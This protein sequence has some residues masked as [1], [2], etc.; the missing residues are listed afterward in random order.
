ML[1]A[2]ASLLVLS[3]APQPQDGAASEPRTFQPLDVFELEWAADPQVSPDGSRVVYVRSRFAVMTDA[4]RTDLWLLALDETPI[5]HRPLVT[6][7]ANVSSPRWSPSGDRLLYVSSEDA[8]AQI[9]C[10][11]MES[12][13]TAALTHVTE[14][15]GSLAWSPDGS[16][17]AFT[18]F[19]PK[20]VKPFA[21]MPPKPEGATWAEAPRVV[22][23]LRA[24]AEA[25]GV[26]RFHLGLEVFAEAGRVH[27][28]AS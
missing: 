19:V 5:G 12:G 22:E 21:E 28:L 26:V 4:T 3:A 6:G 24:T 11:W 10:R 27:N 20:K 18:M 25:F 8:G 17:I 9:F 23:R 2:A 14:S 15:P 16:K 1:F 7:P 13:A